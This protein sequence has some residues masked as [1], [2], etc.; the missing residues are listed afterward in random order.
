MHMRVGFGG[1]SNSHRQIDGKR[2]GQMGMVWWTEKHW[3]RE[4]RIAG[5]RSLLKPREWDAVSTQEEG[6]GVGLK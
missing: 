2:R 6:G 3:K 1:R 4:G 5:V